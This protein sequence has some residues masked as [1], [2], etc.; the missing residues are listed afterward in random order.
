MTLSLNNQ[1][2]SVES[3]KQPPTH[4]INSQT[5]SNRSFSEAVKNTN[6]TKTI[7]TRIWKT[8]QTKGG[9]LFDISFL[10]SNIVTGTIN[11]LV[12]EQA[13]AIYGCRDIKDK[14]DNK[15]YLEAYIDNEEES[16]VT[17]NGLTFDTPQGRFT[18]IP[19][20]ALDDDSNIV[21]LTLSKLPF[22]P[23]RF[24]VPKLIA[25][26]TPYGV[27]H[28]LSLFKDPSGMF[29]GTGSAI[30]CIRNSTDNNNLTTSIQPL[31]HKVPYVDTLDSFHAVW[32]NMPTWC[33]YCHEEGHSKYDCAKS[34][35]SMTCYYCKDQGHRAA[36]CPKKTPKKP[37]KTPLANQTPHDSTRSKVDNTPV[38]YS[39]KSTNLYTILEDQATP[40]V[41]D[42]IEIGDA[43]NTATIIAPQQEP[44]IGNKRPIMIDESDTD[45][46]TTSL[47]EYIE[48]QANELNTRQ[49]Y[50]EEPDLDMGQE[51]GDTDK[52]NHNVPSLDIGENI[53]HS[54]SITPRRNPPL[55]IIRTASGRQVRPPSK[56]V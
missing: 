6:A 36:T 32:A 40:D 51:Q 44:T 30:L 42:A 17:T 12:R 48:R 37:R 38:S 8:S 25:S 29:M 23:E 9:L 2:I 55:P 50:V 34:I 49:Q 16:N 3:G 15:R 54:P 14:R 27:V 47:D 52:D 7:H 1:S 39:P 20:Q 24:L 46:D 5:T 33:R 19:C 13:P 35:A 18:T 22:E 11:Q 43:I 10:S 26:L 21:R 45:S 31:Q 56:Y 4:S 53:V 28:D 41:E